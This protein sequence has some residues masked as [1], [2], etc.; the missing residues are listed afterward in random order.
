MKHT[1]PGQLDMPE[2]EP[3]TSTLSSRR[4]LPSKP[5]LPCDHGLFSDEAAQIDLI[6]MLQEPVNGHD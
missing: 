1:L 3:E 5:Q 6:E 2:C 4:K